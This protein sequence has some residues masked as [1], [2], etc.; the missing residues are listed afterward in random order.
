MSI[1]IEIYLPPLPN[2]QRSYSIICRLKGSTKPWKQSYASES[3]RTSWMGI[4]MMTSQVHSFHT[5]RAFTTQPVFRP[6]R[7]YLA[8]SHCYR[9][10]QSKEA[11]QQWTSTAK[12]IQRFFVKS[13][14]RETCLLYT[15]PSPR[16]L[17]TSRMPS[18]A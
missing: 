7:R 8:T 9:A 14:R 17:S 3:T 4:G 2:Q 10:T 11:L 1:E 12:K 15:S 16:D 5:T 13:W 18:S 6:S